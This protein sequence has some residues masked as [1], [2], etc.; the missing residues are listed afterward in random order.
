MQKIKLNDIFKVFFKIGLILLG[1][2][3][4]IIPIMKEELI[5]KR[6]WINEDELLDFYCVSQCLPGI[7]AINMSILVGNKLAKLKGAIVSLFAMILSPI[8]SIII[9]AKLLNIITKLPFIE[10]LLWGVNISVIVLIYLAL[11]DMWQKSVIDFFCGFWFLFIL[12]LFFL[13][14]SPV[15]LI[16]ISIALGVLIQ[17][18]RREDA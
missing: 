6:N 11:K 18:L 4:V 10:S 17:F 2:G 3:Y 15:I 12:I 7:I 5:Q 9:I 13:N 14:I 8:I 16:L 1:G